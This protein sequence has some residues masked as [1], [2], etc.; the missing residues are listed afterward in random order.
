M[1]KEIAGNSAL[2]GEIKTL[3]EQS[4][5]QLSVTVNATITMLYWQVG[6]RINTEILNNQR[7]E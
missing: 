4:K 3:I 7:A 1:G 5:Q 2:V 6:K